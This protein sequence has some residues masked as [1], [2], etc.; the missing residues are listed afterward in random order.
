MFVYQ[1]GA[2]RVPLLC[3]MLVKSP[4]YG[5]LT[6]VVC[7]V[8]EQ[9]ELCCNRSSTFRNLNCSTDNCS[10]VQVYEAL[11][12]FKS[13]PDWNPFILSAQGEPVVGAQLKIKIQPPGGKAM[14]F[15]PKVLVAERGKEFRWLGR[16]LMPGLFDGEHSFTF[17][18]LPGV[19]TQQLLSGLWR[20]L[21]LPPDPPSTGR[22]SGLFSE[23]CS[24]AL[25]IAESGSLAL[26]VSQP[27]P[28]KRRQILHGFC[29]SQSNEKQVLAFGVLGSVHKCCK[30]SWYSFDHEI[31]STVMPLLKQHLRSM[32][33]AVV[34]HQNTTA[35]MVAA[36]GCLYTAGC[37]RWKDQNVHESFCTLQCLCYSTI[38]CSAHTYSV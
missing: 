7:L 17:E 4:T 19:L 24:H 18:G 8:H 22:S 26:Y 3:L 34:A 37:S 36:A 28:C 11:I 33:T 20:F 30:H 32:S 29:P 1:C 27:L 16:V 12:D 2:F 35:A 6:S 25:Y 23:E 31:T 10:C 38:I 9:P 21:I 15:S 14:T 5:S 13:Y